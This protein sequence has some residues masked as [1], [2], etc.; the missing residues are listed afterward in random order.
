M[1]CSH[2]FKETPVEKH[3]LSGSWFQS[4]ACTEFDTRDDLKSLKLCNL[5]KGL[6]V[7]E[8]KYH[9]LTN[10]DKYMDKCAPLT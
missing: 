8:A 2:C 6:L 10:A 1:R 5:L 3:I 7:K 9:I 4:S